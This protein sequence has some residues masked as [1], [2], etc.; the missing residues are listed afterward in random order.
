MD[1]IGEGM[2]RSDIHR[3]TA[4]SI[5]TL[6]KEDNAMFVYVL[7][8]GGNPLMPTNVAETYVVC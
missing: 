6:R 1:N 2:Q 7:D 3:L 4:K 8:I 5:S